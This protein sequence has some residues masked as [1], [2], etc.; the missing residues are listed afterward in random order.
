[1][2]TVAE[3]FAN[4]RQ[5]FADEPCLLTPEGWLTFEQAGTAA[6]GARGVLAESGCGAGDRVVLA[7][8]NSAVLRILE[9]GVLEGGLVR[10]AV[11]PRLH[12]REIAAIADDAGARVV[13][14]DPDAVDALRTAVDERGIDVA[15]LSC[16]DTAAPLTPGTL[17]AAAVSAPPAASPAPDDLAMLLY[18][19]GTTGRPKG[20]TVSHRSWLEQWERA[21]RQLPPVGPGD[22]VLAVAPMTHFAGSIGLDC[23]AAGAATIPLVYAGP[24]ELLAALDR[25]G[26]TILPL[27]PVML[28]E[29]A[30]TAGPEHEAALSRLRTVPYGGSSIATAHLVAATRLLPGRLVQFYG[31][32]EALAPLAVLSPA[33][34]DEAVRLLAGDAREQQRAADVLSSAGRWVDGVQ[35]RTDGDELVVAGDVVTSGY[36]RRDELNRRVFADGW[37]R[38]G[39]LVRFDDDRLTVLSRADDVVVSGGFNIYPGEVERVL[40][41]EPGLRDVAVVGL[42]HPRWGHGIV[43]AVVL[44]DAHDERYAGDDG[45]A[46]LLAALVARTRTSLAG[47]KKPLDVRILP[48]L[49]RN[50]AGKLDRNRLRERLSAPES[51]HHAS[52]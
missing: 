17:Q 30:V 13:C 16:A 31:L 41:A 14:C 20:A 3:Q 2:T 48:D 38:T 28:A 33:D 50:A 25:H 42:P 44:D 37:F 39:D 18:S 32:A 1:M 40:A 47:Y 7:L 9:Q 4:A 34:H 24:A 49:P 45:R 6:D 10:V 43:A 23:A 35:A 21:M 29:L 51:D 52:T 8:Q 27:A 36:W 5:A 19:S 22:I 12:A 26:P 11:S 15:V 46:R